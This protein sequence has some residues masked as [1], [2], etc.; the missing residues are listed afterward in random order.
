MTYAAQETSV[1]D[2]R[3]YWLYRFANSNGTVTRL[4]STETDLTRTDPVTSTSQ[5]WTAAPIAHGNLEQSGTVERASVEF[6]FP[7]SNA[8]GASFLDVT[9]HVTTLTIYRGHLSD[10]SNELRPVWKGRVVGARAVDARVIVTG[11]TV[12]TSLR[13]PGCRAR[14]MRICRHAL[15]QSGCNLDKADFAVLGTASNVNGRVVTVAE[16]IP[17]A[18]NDYRAGIIEWNGI[19]GFVRTHSGST[20]TL[21]TAIPGLEEAF[22]ADGP[23]SVT[24]YPGCDQS[25]ARCTDRFENNLNFGGFPWMTSLNPFNSSIA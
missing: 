21:L 17:A 11:E 25:L 10:G 14:T 13:N 12:H 24:L 19:F 22:D 1:A 4:A 6:T 5:T 23:Q 9:A 20:L 15:Y 16:A 2:G 3:P 7:L 18:A 8:F